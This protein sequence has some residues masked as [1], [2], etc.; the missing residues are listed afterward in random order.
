[1][2]LSPQARAALFAL[3]LAVSLVIL[4]VFLPSRSPPLYGP[5]PLDTGSFTLANPGRDA[6]GIQYTNGSLEGGARYTV[7]ARADFWSAF[8]A[9]VN[10][11]AT[12]RV[13]GTW[14]ATDPTMVVISWNA[15]WTASST[16]AA[17]NYGCAGLPGQFC[18]LS[19][20]V[21][22]TSGTVDVVLGTQNYLCTDPADSLGP[23]VD[24]GYGLQGISVGNAAAPTGPAGAA[25]VSVTFVSFNAATVTVVEPLV[26]L[27]A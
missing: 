19:V 9:L 22:A 18:S 14:T 4:G 23:C 8:V 7:I 3:P 6:L 16:V 25:S 26:F 20:L 1:M 12:Y 24:L 27:P 2:A 15:L 21:T 11:S 17:A 10:Q 13:R 5:L